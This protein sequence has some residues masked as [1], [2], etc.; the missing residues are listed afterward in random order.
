VDWEDACLEFYRTRR[1]VQTA[2]VSQVRQPVYKQS[3][4]RYKHY[5]VA[6]A[7]LFDALPGP[8]SG[9]AKQPAG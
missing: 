4:A 7:D 5:E 6:L 9:P 2:S 1:P 8:R 3:V